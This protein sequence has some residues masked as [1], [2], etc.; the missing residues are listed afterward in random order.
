MTQNV[1]DIALAQLNRLSERN[2][3][4]RLNAV[5]KAV[6][7]IQ[8]ERKSEMKYS[9]VSH[10]AVTAAV[11]PHM[12]EQGIIYYPVDMKMTQNGN[13][14]EV[15]M[16]V[17]FQSIDDRDDHMDVVCAGFGIDTSDKGPGKAIS[18]SVKYALLKALGLESGDDP[19]MQQDSVHESLEYKTLKL[20]IEMCTDMNQLENEMVPQLQRLSPTL[21]KALQQSLRTAYAQ[22]KK[23]LQAPKQEQDLLAEADKQ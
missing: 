15:T 19:D 6:S 8:K 4:Q 23:A 14:T 5:Q 12:V 11:R 18:Y 17:R 7:Y 20:A 3:F 9:I 22:K 13:R 21:D 10:D 1:S 16:S 2:V